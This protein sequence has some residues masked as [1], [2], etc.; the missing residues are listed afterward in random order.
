MFNAAAD[1]RCSLLCVQQADGGFSCA[2]ACQLLAELE[3]LLPAAESKQHSPVCHCCGSVLLRVSVDKEGHF[4]YSPKLGPVLRKVFCGQPCADFFEEL[5]KQQQST[6][7]IRNASNLFPKDA[8]QTDDMLEMLQ[9]QAAAYSDVVQASEQAGSVVIAATAAINAGTV[10]CSVVGNILSAEDA[11]ASAL[12][13]HLDELEED[14][15]QLLVLSADSLA[16]CMQRAGP[17]DTPNAC[18]VAHYALLQREDS[19]LVKKH[20]LVP[21]AFVVVA[22]RSINAGDRILLEWPKDDKAPKPI[23]KL[24]M[25]HR[26]DDL[27]QGIIRLPADI[28]FALAAR[29]VHLSP[30]AVHRENEKKLENPAGAAHDHLHDILPP[31]FRK[32]YGKFTAFAR[33][34]LIVEQ[35]LDGELLLVARFRDVVYPFFSLDGNYLFKESPPSKEHAKVAQSFKTSYEASNTKERRESR[36]AAARCQPCAAHDDKEEVAESDFAKDE[37]AKWWSQSQPTLLNHLDLDT[38]RQK[39]AEKKICIVNREY[40]RQLHCVLTSD[41]ARKEL[42]PLAKAIA[43]GTCAQWFDTA[44]LFDAPYNARID[45]LLAWLEAVMA[46]V[47]DPTLTYR[48]KQVQDAVAVQDGLFHPWVIFKSLCAFALQIDGQSFKMRYDKSQSALHACS[49]FCR[50]LVQLPF[51]TLSCSR[52]SH[53]STWCHPQAVRRQRSRRSWTST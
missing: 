6:G 34:G 1:S 38:L 20:L 27:T 24:A 25:P 16:A 9:A 36:A 33:D 22:E 46:A 52:S 28:P 17:T 12:Y 44:L 18:I 11:A 47:K 35:E 29:K 53:L 19:P 26:D 43:M 14:K 2:F 32:H 49:S 41:M 3:T 15:Q 8:F 7:R 21:G 45:C 42:S 48:L 30:S 23:D 13:L 5:Q 51:T 40:C 4:E 37:D 31:S 10:I 50:G 39:D